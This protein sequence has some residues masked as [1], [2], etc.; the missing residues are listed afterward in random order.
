MASD[1]VGILG[2]AKGRLGRFMLG[3]KRSST[4]P[5]GTGVPCPYIPSRGGNLSAIQTTAARI[6]GEA[7]S[8]ASRQPAEVQT[9]AN[10]PTKVALDSVATRPPQT[11]DQLPQRKKECR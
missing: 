9:A 6:V 8:A 5:G 4:T 1:K 3:R 2:N 7:T 10:I 11:D